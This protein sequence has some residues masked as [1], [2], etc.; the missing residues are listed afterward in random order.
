M[1]TLRKLITWLLSL[2]RR[3]SPSPVEE[4]APSV[5]YITDE[6]GNQVPIDPTTVAPQVAA[7]AE[8]PAPPPPPAN[9]QQKRAQARR[10]WRKFFTPNMAP[11]WPR[12]KRRRNWLAEASWGPPSEDFKAFMAQ[13]QPTTDAA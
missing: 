10:E 1:R 6:Y 13:Y 7:A 2:F 11:R 3:S 8:P 9:R 5:Y 12:R 4:V